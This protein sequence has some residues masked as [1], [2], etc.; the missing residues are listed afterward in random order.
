MDGTRVEFEPR[1]LARGEVEIGE[2]PVGL[3]GG[4]QP[5]ARLDMHQLRERFGRERRGVLSA[6]LV[7]LDDAQNLIRMRAGPG[8]GMRGVVH[9][10]REF[11]RE[12]SGLGVGIGHL[13]RR[14]V[15]RQ[16]TRHRPVLVGHGDRGM[17]PDFSSLAVGDVGAQSGQPVD[18][19]KPLPGGGAHRH[20]GQ[21][22]G[23]D[24]QGRGGDPVQVAARR[25]LD[26]LRQGTRPPRETAAPPGE[27]RL[28][29]L[30]P[31][32]D[33]VEYARFDIR[34]HVVTPR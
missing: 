6:L 25:E 1:R 29:D 26:M 11:A 34:V 12:L 32:D 15:Q 8:G 10:R 4:H 28:L 30:Q 5:R 24:V 18:G 20:T 14:G 13:E 17:E 7:D 9:P 33:E 22:L 16:R 3:V 23:V 2:Q 19:G 31:I 27:P 21:Q